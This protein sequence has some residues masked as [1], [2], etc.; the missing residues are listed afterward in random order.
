MSHAA[1]ILA[2]LAVPIAGAFLI[3][4]TARR[5]VL[6]GGGLRRHR[7][8][9]LRPRPLARAGGGGGR[10]APRRALRHRAGAPHRV[11]ARAAGDAVRAD[12]V[13]PLDRDDG[14]FHRLRPRQQGGA[15]H[16]LLRLLRGRAGE[17]HRRRLRRQHVHAVPLLRGADALHLSAGD[18]QRHGGGAA[19]GPDLSRHPAVH[20]DPAAALRDPLDLGRGGDPRLPDGRDPRRRRERAHRRRAAGALHVRHRQGGAHAAPRLAA[21]GDGGADAGE[22]AAARGR[23]GEGR[24]VH[25]AQGASSTSSASTSCARWRAA[26]G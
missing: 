20:L 24:R 14:L 19:R 18:P 17:R 10:G 21:G 15:P 8:G 12:R 25:G 13:L 23:R 11:R 3:W 2:A 1:Q 5:P 26:S 22:R 6:A 4:A 16:P 9:A 7:G